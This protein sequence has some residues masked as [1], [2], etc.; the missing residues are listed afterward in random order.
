MIIE[1]TAYARAG[2]LGNPSDGYFGKTISVSIRNFNAS[3][4]LH[5][6]P[7]LRIEPSETDKDQFKNVYELVDSVD[8]NGYYGGQRLI[9]AAITRFYKY[10]RENKI[11]LADNNFTIGYNSNI[12]R[13]IG[14]AG[15][16]AIITCVFRALMKFY[17]VD[18]PMEILPS[19][20][21][22]TEH[23]ELGITAGLQDRVIQVYE[24]CVY[25]DFNKSQM[26]KYGYGK[27]CSIDTKLLPKL[28]LAYNTEL[29]KVSGSILNTIAMHYNEG[30]KK[31][32]STLAAIADCAEQ[33]RAAIEN[34]DHKAL[35][36]IINKNFDLRR[37]IMK[38][39]KGDLEMVETARKCGASAKFAGSGGTIIGSYDSAA[40]FNSLKESLKKTGATVIKASI[41]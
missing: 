19:L 15:S 12:P 37:K 9:K 20:I 18:I 35:G 6:S 33:G 1:T 39:S 21:L 11:K 28:Y 24:G 30:D 29:S 26:E 4:Y 10:V 2:L 38:I 17:N 5:I 32:H 14:M 7:E 41:N 25:M 27:Y 36:E 34:K 16:S 40:T 3:V 8:T 22:S 23:D 31:V 13:Q